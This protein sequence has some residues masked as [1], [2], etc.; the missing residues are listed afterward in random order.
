MPSTIPG[1]YRQ[2]GSWEKERWE[3]SALVNSKGEDRQMINKVCGKGWGVIFNRQGS[4]G[5]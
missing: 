3:Y 2:N 5:N 1:T 4:P